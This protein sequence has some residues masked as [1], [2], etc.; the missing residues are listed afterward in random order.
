M[1]TLR[2]AMQIRHKK[3]SCCWDSVRYDRSSD[4]DGN[5]EYDVM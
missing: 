1:K 3:L 2:K 5:R 4:S